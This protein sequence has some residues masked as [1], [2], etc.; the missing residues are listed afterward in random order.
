MDVIEHYLIGDDGCYLVQKS[1]S[2]Y[3]QPIIY[4]SLFFLIWT[5]KMSESFMFR[6]FHTTVSHKHLSVREGFLSKGGK[7]PNIKQSWSD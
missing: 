3:I 1:F 6:L 5:H 2:T 4:N 7:V